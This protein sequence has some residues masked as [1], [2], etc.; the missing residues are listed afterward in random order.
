M[1]YEEKAKFLRSI[2]MIME[3]YEGRVTGT[4]DLVFPDSA[5]DGGD[6]SIHLTFPNMARISSIPANRG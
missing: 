5:L 1:S 4:M 2:G 6:E 3:E